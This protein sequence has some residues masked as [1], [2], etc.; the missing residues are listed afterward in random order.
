MKK[1][2]LFCIFFIFSLFSTFA[3]KI[4]CLGDSITYGLNLF[5]RSKASYP[6]VL[7]SLLGEYYEVGNFGLSSSCVNYDGDLPYVKSQQ[8]ADLIDFD[9][10]IVV[11]FLGTNDARP[12]NWVDQQKFVSDYNRLLSYIEETIE[13]VIIV[14]VSPPPVFS[15]IF[16]F[17]SILIPTEIKPAIIQVAEERELGLID[18]YSVFE[19]KSKLFPD[20]IHPSS[21]GARII[22]ETVY[23]FLSS[24][25]YIFEG[26]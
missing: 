25:N 14:L 7:D 18:L 16:G 26:E 15:T 13:D 19:G 23:D 22:A 5:Y 11:F 20:T 3:S 24:N 9:P 8:L 10:E 17:N 21:E 2:F 12:K 6:A 1:V 4:A